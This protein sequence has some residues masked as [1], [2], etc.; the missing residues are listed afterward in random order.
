MVLLYHALVAT[1]GVLVQGVVRFAYTTWIGNTS[2]VLAE[3]SAVLSLAVYFSLFWSAGAGVAAMRFIP[4]AQHG[5]PAQGGVLR[6]LRRSFWV[7][8]ALAAVISFPLSYYF[9]GDIA[10]AAA[11]TLLVVSYGAYT[12]SRGTLLGFGRATRATVLDI[13]SAAVAFGVLLAVTSGGAHW[14]LLLPLSVGYG[15]YGFMAWP[16][17]SG[18][19]LPAHQRKQVLSFTGYAI[20]G[21][22]AA[23]GLLPAVM[24]FVQAFDVKEKADL[25]AAALTLATPANMLAQSL[26]QVL[27]QY[28]SGRFGADPRQ[29]HRQA[30][31]IFGLSVIGFVVI[32]GVLIVLAPWLMSI[33]FPGRYEGGVPTLQLLLAI[34]AVSS[35]TSVPGAYLMASGRH[36]AY[37]VAS[38]CAT[39]SG[40][41]AMAFLAPAHGLGGAIAGFAAGSVLSA[42]SVTVLAFLVRPPALTVSEPAQGD[43]AT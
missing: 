43:I 10:S 18:D 12:F 20:F 26:N 21:L 40:V 28:F 8:S 5:G 41:A 33:V 31:I 1:L 13:V 7:A 30:A 11:G 9:T 35:L 37:S 38:F 19:P 22:V 24:L 23:G 15:L 32:F 16:R 39:V 34:V 42:A 3:V 25:F 6:L 14:A 4:A 36:R 29:T 17:Q 2:S 27:V